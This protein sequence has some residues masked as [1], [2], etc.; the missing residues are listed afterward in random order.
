MSE[1]SQTAT[2]KEVV[3][4]GGGIMSSTL[5]IFLNQLQPDWSIRIYERLD[6]VAMESS[7]A[8]NNAGTGHAGNLEMNYTPIKNGKVD[9]SKALKVAEQFEVSKQFWSYLVEKNILK[10]T[11]F[12]SFCPHHAVVFDEEDVNFLKARYE[13]MHVTP[14]FENMTYTEDKEV[15]KEWFPL[16][17]EGRDEKQ[18]MAS[19]R[20]EIGTDVDYGA[21]TRHL[22][23]YI[24]ANKAAELNTQHDVTDV[25]RGADG[26]WKIDVKDLKTGQNETIRADYVFIGAGGH[27]LPLLLGTGIPE[28]KGFG[29]FPVSGQ[30]LICKNEDI[31]KR[32]TVKAYGKAKLGAP[33]MSVPH[34]DH[35]NIDGKTE[36]LFGPFAGFSTN[37]LREGSK[38]DLFKSIKLSNMIPMMQAGL[39]NLDLTK[40]LIQQVKL[41]QPERVEALREFYPNAKDEDWEL[42]VAGQRVQIIKK[43]PDGKGILQ[44]GTELVKSQDGTLSALLG[45][46]PG[47]STAVAIMVDL[48]TKCFP[49]QVKNEGW[50]AKLKEMIPSF[51][52]S[53]N[54]N[55]E[56]LRQVRAKAAEKLRINP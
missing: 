14:L 22:F 48:I 10:D 54:D 34:L 20:V 2:K 4:I 56:L 55:P 52:V 35:R 18:A 3:L 1:N 15:M 23:D 9:I 8:W 37:F 42:R 53:L 40:Y 50:D 5:G 28:S 41:K 19:T 45:A 49:Q 46:S 29:G 36:L 44:F 7:S 33:P 31:I 26:R 12:V 38:W 6:K 30:F 27:S 43:G 25:K 13:A 32:H 11:R 16:L 24:V 47:A 21:L 17:V 51:G 39:A